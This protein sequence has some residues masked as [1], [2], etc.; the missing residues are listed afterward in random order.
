MEY[1]RLKPE[2]NLPNI[3][4][5]N[6][7]RSVVIVEETVNPEWQV[8]VS[9][10][11]VSSGCLYM[12]AWGNDCTSWDNSVDQ[13]NLEEFNYGDIPEQKFVMTTWHEDES[14][15]EVFWFSKNN[16]FHPVVELETTLILHISCKN[17]EKE[18]L[19]EYNN[20]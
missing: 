15:K 3:N 4:V 5:L 12:M 16:A 14:L 17:K 1:L 7:F 19:T 6:P 2:S 20:A 13:A 10:W 11:L 18:Y 9:N 8:Q